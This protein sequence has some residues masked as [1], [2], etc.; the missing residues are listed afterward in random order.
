MME[1]KTIDQSFKKWEE[2]NVGKVLAKFPERKEEF[3]FDTGEE[4][5]RL[6][7]PLDAEI[8]YENDLGYPGQFPYTRGVQPTMYRGKLWTMRMYAGFATAEES[9][10]RYKFL[11]DQ[12]SMGLSVAFD[13]PTQMGYDSNDS[14]AEGEVGKVGVAIDSLADM[15]IL[16]DGIPLDKVSTSMTINAPASVLLAMYIA[17]AKKQGVTPDKLRGTIQNDILKEYVA[18]GTYIFPVGPSMRLITDIF[19]Y[20]SKNVPKWNTISISGYHI[21]EAGANAIE[22]VAFTLADGIAYVNAALE[23]GLHVDDFAPRL[24]FFFNAHN[25]LLEEVAKFRAARRIWANTMKNRF[26]AENPKSWALKFHTQTAGCTLTA[27]QPENNIVRVA[28]QTLAAVLGGT[29]SLHTNSKDEALALPT[30]DSVRVALRTQQ[31]VGYESGVADSID[32]LAGSYYIESLTNKIEKEA[33]DLISKIDELGGAPQAIEKGYIQQEIMD[34]A[35]K[36]QKE[37]ENNERVIV[38]V[39][40]FKIEEEAPKGLLRVDPSVGER[41]K[42]KIESLKAKRDNEKVKIALEKLRNACNSDKNVMPYILEAV[43]NY[44]TLG[45]VCGVMRAEFGEYKQ[46][47]MI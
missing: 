20:C 17:V 33:L 12:G 42:E 21:R 7:T 31:I 19:D 46:T 38:G 26:K 6:Y 41:Q 22:E 4:V 10:Q 16:F 11:I 9:N 15:E 47:V 43:E 30:E 23:A 32:P 13:L 34:S 8:D 24:S 14:I 29:Q 45:E 28:I 5:K 36:Y 40:K 18:R 44:A 39:N 2:G 3:K 27:Q 37:I 35:Y 25:N 1:K